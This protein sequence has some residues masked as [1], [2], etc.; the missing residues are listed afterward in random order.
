MA[1]TDDIKVL[2]Q[3]RADALLIGTVLMEAE[4]PSELVYD[5]KRIYNQS[6][7]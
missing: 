6:K 2:A 7:K 5:Y 3:S 4:K 1:D